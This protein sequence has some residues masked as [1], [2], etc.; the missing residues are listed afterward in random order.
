MITVRFLIMIKISTCTLLYWN[1]VYKDTLNK[2]FRE[3]I[4]K[5]KLTEIL[6]EYLKWRINGTIFVFCFQMFI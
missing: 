3:S 2:T 1:K 5:G 6:H 4:S